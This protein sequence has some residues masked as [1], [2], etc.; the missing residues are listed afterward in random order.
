[1]YNE[2]IKPVINDSSLAYGTC[3]VKTDKALYSSYGNIINTLVGRGVRIR[4]SWHMLSYWQPHL[5]I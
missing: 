3:C 1:M 4:K 2:M 5:F